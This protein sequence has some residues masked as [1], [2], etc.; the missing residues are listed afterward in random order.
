MPTTAAGPGRPPPPASSQPGPAPDDHAELSLEDLLSDDEFAKQLQAGMA[1][2]IG[3]LEKSVRHTPRSPC[4]TC[5]PARLTDMHRSARCR[6]SSREYSGNWAQNFPALL[7][8]RPPSQLE[9]LHHRDPPLLRRLLTRHHRQPARHPAVRPHRRPRPHPSKR[10][11]DGRWSGCRRL[12]RRRRQQR[13]QQRV[14]VEE[15]E[16]AEAEALCRRTT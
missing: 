4:G 6:P 11:F 3:E 9:R 2:L 5:R 13:P 8:K 1:D 12:V 15:E 10:R 7:G 14:V 16:E